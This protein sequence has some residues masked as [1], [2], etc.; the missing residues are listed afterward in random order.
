M[1]RKV[2]WL[3]PA[4]HAFP[5]GDTP[6][7]QSAPWTYLLPGRHPPGSLF[8]V[9]NPGDVLHV[10]ESWAHSTWNLD[11]WCISVGHIGFCE[12]SAPNER[13]TQSPS[14]LV[15]RASVGDIDACFSLGRKFEDNGDLASACDWY[16][17]AADSGHAA[18]MFSLWRLRSS[19]DVSSPMHWL[20]A[21]AQHGHADAQITLGDILSQSSESLATAAQ[22]SATSLYAAAAAQQHPGGQHRM[23]RVHF[24]AGDVV[25]GDALLRAAAEQGWADAEMDLGRRAQAAG[26]LA[27]ARTWYDKAAGQGHPGAMNQLA[28]L[29]A[30]AGDHVSARKWLQM[31]ADR[32]HRGAMGNL[33]LYFERGVGG[34][35][36][37]RAAAEL[38]RL[39]SAK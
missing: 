5:F 8:C 32:G 17:K 35:P 6:L 12:G 21:A 14:S 31:A 37:S 11:D 19:H 7:N 36:D 33:A 16:M 4:G 23:S 13:P 30:Q 22:G 20:S 9:L 2:W 15:E 18:S 27:E 38:R 10:P 24:E 28:V 26:D 29:G 34:A 1:G 39:A 3:V 25:A